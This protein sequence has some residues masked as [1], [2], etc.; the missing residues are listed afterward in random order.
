MKVWTINDGKRF[1]NKEILH[2]DNGAPEGRNS[3]PIAWGVS[4]RSG[5]V[6]IEM[7]APKGRHED[8][9][10]HKIPIGKRPPES[11]A[12]PGLIML[13]TLPYLGLT[14]QAIKD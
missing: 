8:W 13:E 6:D 1:L 12:L 7:K 14:P 11:V 10:K 2:K 5:Q 3:S 4:P 9:Y